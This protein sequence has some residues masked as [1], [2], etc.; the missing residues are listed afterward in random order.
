M[1]LA[2]PRCMYVCMYVVLANP[3]CMY[4]GWFWPTLGVCMYVCMYVCG[5]GQP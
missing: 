1:V 5:S 3:R 2:N 4:V